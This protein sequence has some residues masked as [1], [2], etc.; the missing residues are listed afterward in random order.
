MKLQELLKTALPALATAI[1]GPVGGVV[2]SAIAAKLGVPE[3]RVSDHLIANPAEVSKL[4]GLDA[5][6]QAFEDIQDARAREIELSK[7]DSAL[8]KATTP[9]LA[10]ATVGLA[11]LFCGLLMFHQIPADQENIVIYV[12]GFIT[13]SASQVLSYYFGS[14]QSSRD[15]TK[16]LLKR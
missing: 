8:A 2:V 11:F 16:E 14:S 1:G 6:L 3:S 7:S 12:L 5:E 15:K 10:L 4:Q 13:A 9:G